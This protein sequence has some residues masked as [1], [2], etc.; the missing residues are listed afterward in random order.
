MRVLVEERVNLPIK[1]LNNFKQKQQQSCKNK[2]AIFLTKGLLF[3]FPPFTSSLLLFNEV[4]FAVDIFG[5]RDIEQHC[6]FF[7]WHSN[8]WNLIKNYDLLWWI[9]IN[10]DQLPQYNSDNS[11]KCYVSFW[12]TKAILFDTHAIVHSLFTFIACNGIKI[13]FI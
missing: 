7:W 9:S 11:V 12:E 4:L 10:K 13:S 6:L 3:T 1:A 2:E 8:L 5:K